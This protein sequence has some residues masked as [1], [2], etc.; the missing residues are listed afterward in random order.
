MMKA[1][2]WHDKHSIDEMSALLKEG[3]VLVGSSDTVFGLL[4]LATDA[5][6]RRLDTI[7]GRQDRPYLVLAR[8]IEEVKNLV[9]LSQLL[10]IEN[11]LKF[12]WPGPLTVIFTPS[13]Y[14]EGLYAPFPSTPVRKWTIA[15]RVPKH[16][17]LQKLLAQTGILFSTSAN[18][19]GQPVPA[20]LDEM[21]P[22]I[23]AAVDGIVLDG[24][25]ETSTLSTPSTIIDATG[26]KLVIVREG[27]YSKAGLE[28]L[29]D[30]GDKQF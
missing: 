19:T 26:D 16:A 25:E 9:D 30:D 6:K 11:F 8:S 21:D 24:T 23:L 17:G 18:K 10:Q 15:V 28:R 27:A 2:S 4:A 12:C 1:Y 22:E 5:G 20:T 29:L 14:A 3:R 7:K 13:L